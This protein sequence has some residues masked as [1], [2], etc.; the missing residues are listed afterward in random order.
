G[1]QDSLMWESLPPQVPKR[2][3]RG[4]WGHTWPSPYGG[5]TTLNEPGW[6]AIVLEWLDAYLGDGPEPQRVGVM[7]FSDGTSWH[8]STRGWKVPQEVLYLGGGAVRPTATSESTTFRDIPLSSFNSSY[9][10]ATQFSG[11]PLPSYDAAVCDRTTANGKVAAVYDSAPLPRPALVAGNPYAY[12]SVA[13][14]QPRGLVNVEVYDVAPDAHCADPSSDNGTVGVRWLSSGTVDL[15]YYRSHFAP[16]PLP[17]DSPQWVR[18]D[19]LD[20]AASLP[21]DHWLR[22]V[23]SYGSALEKSVGRLQDVPLITIGGDSQLVLPVFDGTLGGRRPTQHY[24]P[25]PFLP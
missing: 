22:V 14:D 13:S 21:A 5:I 12:L 23:V 25:R 2:F 9:G 15:A 11:L 1:F 16:T 18:V 8:S 24:P 17:V 6:E 7:D 4:W 10:A 3:I 20:T 19:L